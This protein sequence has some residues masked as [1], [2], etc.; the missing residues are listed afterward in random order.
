MALRSN[1]FPSSATRLVGRAR[2]GDHLLGMTALA[3]PTNRSTRDLQHVNS[4]YS[5]PGIDRKPARDPADG[6]VAWRILSCSWVSDNDGGIR[7]G[8][9]CCTCVVR[10]ACSHRAWRRSRTMIDV[11]RGRLGRRH[12]VPDR[13]G[14]AD[15][16]VRR[17]AVARRC[18]LNAVRRRRR[19][20]PTSPGS[21]LVRSE[22][23][24]LPPSFQELL[25]CWHRMNH[26]RAL[27]V[28][29]GRW[30]DEHR[31]R[32][33]VSLEGSPVM[34]I[35]VQHVVVA[36]TVLAGACLDVR[37]DSARQEASAVNM[38]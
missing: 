33:V 12:R 38:C 37:A 7:R 28:G 19:C 14:G 3:P 32:V 13:H 18:R 15:R 6:S 23:S 4:A 26:R 34:S 17:S 5:H 20:R 35:C 27:S 16:R 31:D 30:T 2:R 11:L 1:V 8:P 9:C 29:V 22:S 21:M 24:L 10:P 36:D 25:P